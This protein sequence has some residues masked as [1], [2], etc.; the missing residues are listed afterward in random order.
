MKDKNKDE[1]LNIYANWILSI[2]SINSYDVYTFG[3]NYLYI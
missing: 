3:G 2:R 1:N